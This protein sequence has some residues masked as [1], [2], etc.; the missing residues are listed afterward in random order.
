MRNIFF[1]LGT[2]VNFEMCYKILLQKEMKELLINPG[3]INDEAFKFISKKPSENILQYLSSCSESS[4]DVTIYCSDGTVAAHKLVLASLSKMLFKVFKCQDHEEDTSILLPDFTVAHITAYF[5]GLFLGQDVFQDSQYSRLNTA[6]AVVSDLKPS[7]I[8]IVVKDEMVDT[9]VKEEAMP[10]RIK[11]ENMEHGNSVD[12]YDD[13]FD[14]EEPNEDFEDGKEEGKESKSGK[15]KFTCK[16]CGYEATTKSMLTKHRLE[17][18][19]GIGR[20]GSRKTPDTSSPI[21]QYFIQDPSNSERRTCKLCNASL[22]FKEQRLIHLA[23]HLNAKHD[24][25]I[26]IEKSRN[27]PRKK[28]N[29]LWEYLDEH[30][31]D[32]F[33]VVCKICG[34]TLSRNNGRKH[35]MNEHKIGKSE[36]LCSFCGKSFRDNYNR[37]IHEIEQHTK[38]YNF[39]CEECGK[40][41]AEKYKLDLHKL[42]KHKD[43]E[44]TPDATIKKYLAKQKPNQEVERLV[45]VHCGSTFA[46]R[47]SLKNHIKVV[48]EGFKLQC[49]H[50]D[51][52]IGKKAALQ[53]HIKSKHEGISYPCPHCNYKATR[54]DNLNTHVK[55]VH[56]GIR[57]KC[58]HCDFQVT[59]KD[60]LD[61]H[62]NSTHT[63]L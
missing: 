46:S 51:Y 16:H 9:I 22:A 52:T 57:L 62:I 48:H 44:T 59:R 15:G 55:T 2:H 38:K 17:M 25:L 39:H 5:S 18:H 41:F 28:S 60:Y 10:N 43:F 29:Q 20:I 34:K 26:K 54:Q 42:E 53:F 7:S 56:E 33:K 32:P 35:I 27:G 23:Y 12:Y 30:P 11:M 4:T 49:P 1:V 50:C 63:L 36:I 45:C 47:V 14:Y 6:L 37:N 19:L 21:W 61:K 58:P 24:I 13:G 3:K 31:S 8:G 40:G